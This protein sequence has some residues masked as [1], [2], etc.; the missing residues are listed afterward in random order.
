MG[1]KYLTY[2]YY[3]SDIPIMTTE[4]K[5]NG[6]LVLLNEIIT[7]VEDRVSGLILA[8]E[9]EKPEGEAI[10]IREAVTDWRQFPSVNVVAE[11][12]KAPKLAI[13]Y[14]LSVHHK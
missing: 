6:W 11:F 4:A 2:G 7:I 12:L 9:A 14:R 3:T 8:K 5:M 13:T 10:R 1:G